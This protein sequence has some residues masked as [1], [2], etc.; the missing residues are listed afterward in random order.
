MNTIELLQLAD[1]NIQEKLAD[2]HRI[3]SLKEFIIANSETLE[4]F[5]AHATVYNSQID[6][7]YVD[8]ETL[9]D[10]IKAFPEKWNKSFRP[11]AGV[12]DYT[13][14]FNG[15]TLRCWGAPP[16]PSCQ[17]IEEEIEVPEQVIPAK[18][19]LRRSL[20]CKGVTKEDA[21]LV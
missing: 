11:D 18:K 2:I 7:D 12:M 6:F 17:I 13:A 5:S 9:L 1:H 16:P 10:V 21:V 8:R 20:N 14:T 15:I 19:E 3:E 4:R